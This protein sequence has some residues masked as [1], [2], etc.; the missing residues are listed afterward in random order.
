MAREILELE[1]EQSQTNLHSVE[2]ILLAQKALAELF[3]RIDDVRERA[4]QTEQTITEMTADI[5]RLDVTK[6]NLTLSMTA[7][8]R[9][10]MLTTAYER[11]WSMSKS[12]EYRECAQLLQAV[13]QLMVHFKSFRSIDQIATLSR[14]VADLQRELQEQICED[15]EITFAKSEIRSRRNTLAE[16]CLVMDALGDNARSRLIMWYCNTQLREYR[17]LFRGNEEVVLISALEIGQDFEWKL[18]NG[19]LHTGRLVGQHLPSIRM[20]Q[21]NAE[22]IRRGACQHLSDGLESQ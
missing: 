1:K 15:F 17:R 20:V 21:A 14:N 11:L 5:K 18:I 2:R 13:V 10:Q 6:R 7:L 19:A 12:R 8:K 3:R 22:D 4:M 16:A 9:L